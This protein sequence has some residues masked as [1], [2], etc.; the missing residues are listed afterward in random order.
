MLDIEIEEECFKMYNG[1]KNRK[2]KVINFKLSPDNRQVLVDPNSMKYSYMKKNVFETWASDLPDDQCL[3][4]LYDFDILI[5]MDGMSSTRRNK[6]GF[7]VWAPPKSRIKDRMILA[8]AKDNL[9]RAIEGIQIEWQLNGREDL[10]V[11]EFI[12][13]LDKQPGIRHAGNIIGFE[14]ES[15]KFWESWKSNG[16]DLSQL[17]GVDC[18]KQLDF[19]DK[20]KAQLDTEEQAHEAERSRRREINYSRESNGSNGNIPVGSDGVPKFSSHLNRTS[21]NNSYSR[22]SGNGLNTCSQN[23]NSTSPQRSGSFKSSNK[24][25]SHS[26]STPKQAEVIPSSMQPKSS[27]VSYRD[28]VKVITEEYIVEESSSKS[29]KKKKKKDKDKDKANMTPEEKRLKKEKKKAK[30][31]AK[32]AAK[33]ASAH[34]GNGSNAGSSILARIQ[35]MNLN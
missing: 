11:T 19:Y 28:G 21:S 17:H 13:T 3:Y 26:G 6:I 34:N 10:E 12:K 24:Y 29:K 35:Q 33:E 27:V 25:G 31:A 15:V 1:M 32:K 23:S 30:K 18:S 7:V 9:R 22:F 14:G 20:M 4:S 8:S 5:G 2:V 16:R